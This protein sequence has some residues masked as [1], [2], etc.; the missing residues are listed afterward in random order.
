MSK[1]IQNE[2]ICLCGEEISTGI[3]SEVKESRFFSILAVKSEIVPTLK[4]CHLLFDLWINPVKLE[5]N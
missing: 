5:K 4:K 1:T 2:F 3:I